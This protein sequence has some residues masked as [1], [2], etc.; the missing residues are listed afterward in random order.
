[1]RKDNAEAGYSLLELMVVLAIIA[2]VMTAGLPFAF[3]SME[4][5]S[6]ESD[7]RRVAGSLREMRALAMDLQKDVVLSVPAGGGDIIASSEGDRIR[8]SPGTTATIEAAEPG[9]RA[10]GPGRLVIGWD[11]SLSGSLRL[12]SR[13]RALRLRQPAPGAPLRIED[14]VP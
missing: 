4:R 8:L 3:G 12:E 5:L 7:A 11:G 6:L 9:G 13:G 1:M 2:V 14:A 10:D